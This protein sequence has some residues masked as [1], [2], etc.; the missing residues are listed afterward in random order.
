MKKTGKGGYFSQKQLMDKALFMN[1]D[2]LQE[3]L[4]R[5]NQ[6]INYN[7]KISNKLMKAYKK[8]NFDMHHDITSKYLKNLQKTEK[9]LNTLIKKKDIDAKVKSRFGD[10]YNSQKYAEYQRLQ[11]DRTNELMKNM[12]NY[13]QQK[14]LFGKDWIK[15]NKFDVLQKSSHNNQF[16]ND[17]VMQY[18]QR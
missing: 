7:H 14:K 15:M 13:K 5:V 3:L 10:K 2:E 9:F 4:N 11:Q 18:K 8:T 12:V 17:L 1:K 16:R 6:R